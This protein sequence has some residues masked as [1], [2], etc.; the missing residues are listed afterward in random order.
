MTMAL[1]L[2]FAACTSEEFESF[3]NQGE[4][5][6]NRK[7]IGKV[8]LMFD[9]GDAQTRWTA[10]MA[11]EVGDRVGVVL[12]DQNNGGTDEDPMKNYTVNDNQIFT[13]Y[14]YENDGNAWTTNANLVEGNYYFYAPY[15]ASHQGRSLIKLTTPVVQNIDVDAQG[16]PDEEPQYSRPAPQDFPDEEPPSG[17]DGAPPE[18]G[19][20]PFD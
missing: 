12:I 8:A 11:P 15:V 16:A 14:M 2:A 7:D 18:E 13:N 5:L 4:G 1:P 3:N 19:E 20:L 17:P 9:G 10:G 6:N